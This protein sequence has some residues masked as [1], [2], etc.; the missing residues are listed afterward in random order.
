MNLFTIYIY[1]EIGGT[2]GGCFRYMYS[3]FLREA[4]EITANTAL[5]DAAA[6]MDASGKHFTELG[7]LF[8]DVET[9]PNIEER[10]NV[11]TEQFRL[12]AD[13]EEETF[14]NLAVNILESG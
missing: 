14:H 8:E 2:G 5:E 6:M 4:A 10:I 1:I 11:A 13:I 3:R 12:I 9:A 7:L